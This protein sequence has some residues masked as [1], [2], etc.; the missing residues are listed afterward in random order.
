MSASTGRASASEIL[1]LKTLIVGDVRTGKTSLTAGLLD[2]LVDSGQA[3]ELVVIEM[4]PDKLGVGKKLSSFSKRI[5]EVKVVEPEG[6]R[7][8]RL[9]GRGAEEVRKLA[10]LN[11]A[12]I[13]PILLEFARSP[14]RILIVNDLS[15]YLQ[16]GDPEI[17]LS[18]S[19]GADTFIG[20]S[21][22]G[23]ALAEDGGSGISALERIRLEVMMS[24]MDVVLRL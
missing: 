4:A 7:A 23:E 15:I 17:L 3:S 20:N 11:R 8:P 9:E 5:E 18:C 24:E 22:L 21:Y 16:A 1:G 19:R 13:E 2:E 10:E 6:I 12:K 14:S